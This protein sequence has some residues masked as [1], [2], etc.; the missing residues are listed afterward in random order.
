MLANMSL[1]QIGFAFIS[2][3][4]ITTIVFVGS[5][6]ITLNNITAIQGSWEIFEKGRSEKEHSLN[7]L[8]RELGYNGMIH[9]FKNFIL[10]QEPH[11]ATR[12][13]ENLG[14]SLSV[15]RRYK[16]LGTNKAENNALN[17]I[18]EVIIAYKNALE[19]AMQ[20]SQKKMPASEIDRFVRVDDLPALEGLKDIE[21]EIS[22]VNT[23]SKS[24][25][26]KPLIIN[27]V[28]KAIGYGG[29]IHSFK[30]YVLR[31]DPLLVTQALDQ[32]DTAAS[33]ISDYRTLGTNP[34]ESAALAEI[35]KVIKAYRQALSHAVLMVADGATSEVIDKAVK[36][37]DLPAV[38][39]LASL[40]REINRQHNLDAI[41]VRDKLKL[42]T[43]IT[44]IMTLTIGA[45]ML[46]LII[47]AYWL[48]RNKII[49]PLIR[50]TD[51][52]T[53]LAK[54]DL[55]AAVLATKEVKE[56]DT[57]AH[58]LDV[59]KNTAAQR[60]KSDLALIEQEKR[61]RTVLET[62]VDPL[63]TIDDMG[64]ID[65]F[66][67]AA[68]RMFGYSESEAI[69]KNVALLMPEGYNSDHSEYL[70]SHKTT[71]KVKIL[72]ARREIEV[73]R[74]NGETLPVELS[75]SEMWLGNR[76]LFTS[77]LRD[78]S[79]RQRVEKIKN[80]FIATVSHELRTPLTSIRGSL[81]LLS[82]GAMGS[83]PENV[84]KLLNIANNNTDRLLL[85]INDILDVEKIEAGK[86][87]F[88]F[89]EVDLM[90]LVEQALCNNIA[91]AEQYQVSFKCMTIIENCTVYADPDR[92]IQVLNNL[93][94]NAAKFSPQGDVIEVK[95]TCNDDNIRISVSD[96]GQ[97]IPLEFQSKVFD[98]FSQSDSS[99]TRFAGGT[100]L[101]LS[102]SRA[103]IEQHSGNIDFITE[104]NKGT[105]FFFELPAKKRAA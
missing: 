76:C 103:I 62:M 5:G 34:K 69:G 29:M 81:G 20:M 84:K 53:R 63:I 66:N 7:A 23:R 94:S 74:K 15:I 70:S 38:A 6:V 102:I 8:R 61:H 18:T 95:A 58:S 24:Q 54:G 40:T 91:Y 90:S 59:F 55:E 100:G 11:Y 89:Q 13:R 64:R 28:S 52:T 3:L 50:I 73:R 25:L 60:I 51:A 80:E 9:H 97:G 98:K 17:E 48:I 78:I 30:N 33:M 96:H 36:I 56:I 46:L 27:S 67:T 31:R 82:G 45:L 87:D 35:L 4:A 99:D 86:M 26:S 41:K 1:R 49:V 37:N 19:L 105:T 93:I 72:E 32:M 88:N 101:G 42:V 104:Q 79:E 22:L 92:I 77:T 75:L 71:G 44:Q 12:V 16:S 57:L 68:V 65:S 2:T 39:G 83:L 14:G 10:R 47:T 85:L 21:H 43:R